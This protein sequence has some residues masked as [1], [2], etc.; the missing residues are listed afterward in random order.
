M[1]PSRR[2]AGTGDVV[3]VEVPG[4]ADAH[5]A[6]GAV[7][8]GLGRPDRDLQRGGDR[9]QV[10][11][12]EVV[13]DDDGAPLRPEPLERAVEQVAI[14]DERRHVAHRGV[15]E[16]SQLHLHGP[17]PPAAGRVHAGVEDEAMEPG[18]EAIRIAKGRQAP[19][20]A[21]EALLD[22]VSRELGVPEDEA[23]RSIQPRDARAGKHGEG[24]MIASPGPLDESSLVHGHPRVGAATSSRFGWYGARF[25]SKVPGVRA[26]RGAGAAPTSSPHVKDPG[27]RNGIR[28]VA[29]DAPGEMGAIGV[30]ATR[31][32]VA[33][34]MICLVSG[35]VWTSPPATAPVAATAT[36]TDGVAEPPALS[37][38]TALAPTTPVTWGSPSKAGAEHARNYGNALARTVRDGSQRLHVA[39]ATN[40][41]NGTWATDSG[42]YA[43]IYYVRS[44][45]GATWT[46]PRRITSPRKHVTAFGLAAAGSRVYLAYVTQTRI[47]EIDHSAPRVLYVRVNTNHGF[48]DYWKGSVRLTGTTRIVDRP[49]VAAS[50]TD[51]HIAFTSADTGAVIVATSRDRGVTW[52]KRTVGTTTS[53]TNIGRSALPSVAVSGST[54]AVTWA[55]NGDGALRTRVSTDR[56]STWGDI[57]EHPGAS[58][59]RFQTA[60]AGSGSASRG[61][62]A[63]GSSPGSP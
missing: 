47:D 61:S 32:P 10:H 27:C 2:I 29:C 56:G 33:M 63:T 14:G 12:E 50:G 15:V 25:A 58:S 23:G 42:P 40:D 18:L 3:E 1:P 38:G 39:Y 41:I 30:R 28:S 48:G 17:T 54:V 13:Q 37:G 34:A 55:A 31:L 26:R 53:N 43:G 60:V 11:P 6:Q 44:A 57:E 51:V 36:A 49:T 24:V 5:L 21:D 59:F 9:R 20:G 4:D 8:P 35:L 62:P 22:R 7:V 45:T 52:V 19:P 16:R 46:T